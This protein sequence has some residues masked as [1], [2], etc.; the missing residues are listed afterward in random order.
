MNAKKISGFECF[1]SKIRDI[2]K[3]MPLKTLNFL[4]H[5]VMTTNL[6]SFL[7]A[8]YGFTDLN[9]NGHV[10]FVG[11]E[12]IHDLVKLLVLFL[13]A[14]SGRSTTFPQMS[15]FCRIVPCMECC[16]LGYPSRHIFQSCFIHDLSQT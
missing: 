6:R 8:L 14:V 1:L 16:M 15:F 3:K 4:Y 10:S 13:R 2:E 12:R 9:I 11:H 7:K 5:Y